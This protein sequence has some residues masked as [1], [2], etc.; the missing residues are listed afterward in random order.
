MTNP[1]FAAE[2]FLSQKTV[3]THLHQAAIPGAR[4]TL[5]RG[6]GHMIFFSHSAEIISAL[7]EWEGGAN[8]SEGALIE[9]GVIQAMGFRH[10]GEQRALVHR[11]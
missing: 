10:V 6:E 2:L 4:L 1:E 7:A 5:Y 9:A 11:S 3:E 8:A